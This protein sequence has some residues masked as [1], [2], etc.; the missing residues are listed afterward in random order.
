MKIFFTSPYDGRKQYQRYIDVIIATVESIGAQVISPEKTREYQDALSRE[1]IQKLGSRDR[2]HYEFIRQGIANA[3]A[4]IIEASYEDFRVGHE[5]TLAIIYKKPVL[6]LS[7]K[8][9]Y[10]QLIRHEDFQ[11]KKYTEKNLRKLVLDFLSGV[12][13]KILKKRKSTL[14]GKTGDGEKTRKY[15]NIAVLGA[16]NIDLVTK[17]P[18][19]PKENE[20]VISEGLH[21][22]PGGKATNAA[23]GMARLDGAV[24]MIGKIGNDTFGEEVHAV[25]RRESIQTDYVDT[26][27]FI[28]T[29]TV[30]VNVDAKGKNTII[31]NEDANIRINKKTIMDFVGAFDGKK[32]NV[33]CF[34]TTLEP[35]PEIVE[36]AIREFSKRKIFIFCDAAPQT[37]PLPA[38]LY[39]LID[40]LSAN[41]YE[42]TG[43]TG[44]T[45]RDVASAE[46]AAVFLRRKGAQTV[47][48]TLGHLGAVLLEKGHEAPIHIP[49]K[50]VNVVDETAAGDAFRA[51]FVVEYLRTKQMQTALEFANLVGAYAVTRLGAYEALPTREELEF[52]EVFG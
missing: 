23:V 12:S 4:V 46:A 52:L 27:S 25:L 43:M 3:D 32:Q 14:H 24:S 10:G 8:K 36:L 29:G 2:A 15:G 45:V 33:D 42:A 21:L 18:R 48:I 47:I 17:V 20:V 9:D 22:L 19:I 13:R 30:M 1:N 31:V 11:G 16:I 39:P 28:P 35:L 7:Q 5:A 40:V 41:E 44:M 51:G 49:G 38:H 26:D 50:K 6:C 34:Y 37:R